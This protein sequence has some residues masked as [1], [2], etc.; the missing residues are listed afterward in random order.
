[1]SARVFIITPLIYSI[2]VGVII[3]DG[4]L[5]YPS[6][7]SQNARFR[8][9]QSKAHEAY[10]WFVFCILSPLCSSL[11]SARTRL[12]KGVQNYSVRFYTRS[13]PVFTE[14]HSMF[15][16]SVGRKILPPLVVLIDILTPVALAHVIIGDGY[17]HGNGLVLCT[18][19]FTVEEVSRL[20]T[21]LYVRYHI[22]STLRYH[23]GKPTIYI[24]TSSMPTL[25]NLVRPHM[26][27]SFLYKLGE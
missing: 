13:L 17:R 10:L 15:Y 9:E 1:M 23:K 5:Q 6:R 20:M 25:R 2:I 14:L 8:L 11:P 3:E 19:S 27:P 21:V 16:N 7:T 12:Y 26:H 22:D 4:N 24:R 18:H